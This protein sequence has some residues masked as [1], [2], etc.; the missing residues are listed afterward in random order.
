[1][2]ME[3]IQLA[4]IVKKFAPELVPFLQRQELETYVVLRDGVKT[5]RHADVVEIVKHRIYENQKRSY[6][7]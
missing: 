4:N 6:L 3:T 1:M 5:L 2:E 7:Q